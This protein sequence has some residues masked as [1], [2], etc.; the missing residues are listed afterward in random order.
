MV[1]EGLGGVACDHIVCDESGGP[2]GHVNYSCGVDKIE[3]CEVNS[4]QGTSGIWQVRVPQ[5]MVATF[6]R[7]AARLP[8]CSG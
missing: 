8:V 1:Y 4:V 5:K 6:G 2:W 3:G 7:G